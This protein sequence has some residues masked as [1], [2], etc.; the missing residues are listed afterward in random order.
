MH[1]A[2]VIHRDLKPSNLLLNSEC[3]LKIADFGLARS[4]EFKEEEGEGQGGLLTDYVATRWYRAPEILLGSSDY[5]KGVDMWSVG[6]ILGEML[7]GEPIFP[8]E[9]TLNQLEKIME[10]TGRPSPEDIEAI[11]SQ[12]AGSMLESLPETEH[13]SLE[14]M[15]PKADETTI[16][17]IAKLLEFNPDKR[18]TIEESLAHPYVEQFHS[19]NEEEEINCEKKIVIPIDDNKKLGVAAYR[20]EL[21]QNVIKIAEVQKVKRKEK[22]PKKSKK[23]K[24]EALAA[25]PKKKTSSSKKSSTG[26]SSS[27]SSKTKKKS[28]Q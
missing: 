26:K 10:V 12:F 17:F 14:D 13:K 22:K 23:K 27:S 20:N 15:F 6:C 7:L 3:L 24:P 18:I 2:A 19:G 28:G 16:D 9:S 8:G 5:T 1:S 11:N 4:I 25:A 21:Y